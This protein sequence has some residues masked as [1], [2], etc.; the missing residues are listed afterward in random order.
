MPLSKTLAAL[1]VLSNLLVLT[2]QACSFLLLFM[3]CT[4]GVDPLGVCIHTPGCKDYHAVLLK[5]CYALR[6][7]ERLPPGTNL[8]DEDVISKDILDVDGR[9]YYQYESYAPYGTNGTH[10][11]ARATTKVRCL[12]C[13]SARLMQPVFQH[14][15]DIDIKVDE[16]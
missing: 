16:L 8:E 1:I 10:Q 13:C 5:L 14:L 9:T 11:V 4:K 6:M 12:C 7:F 2:S 3:L 15:F